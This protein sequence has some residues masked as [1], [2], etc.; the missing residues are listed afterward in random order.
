MSIRDERKMFEQNDVLADS[1]D[2][3]I[4][5]LNSCQILL[6]TNEDSNETL[7]KIV[8]TLNG[9]RGPLL[10]HP[11][12]LSHGLFTKLRVHYRL[13]LKAWRRSDHS[14]NESIQQE[15]LSELCAFLCLLSIGIRDA[16]IQIAEQLFLNKPLIDELIDCLNV[17]MNGQEDPLLLSTIIGMVYAFSRLQIKGIYNPMH[18]PFLDAIVQYLC[19]VELKEK[20]M[21]PN[22]IVDHRPLIKAC[23]HYLVGFK[24]RCQHHLNL[25]V[26]RSQLRPFTE[27]IQGQN[28][29]LDYC[30]TIENVTIIDYMAT[31]I[32]TCLINNIFTE[33][34]LK[35][36]SSLF[37]TF[38]KI[39]LSSKDLEN[40]LLTSVMVK[41]LYTFS[42]NNSSCR[43]SLTESVILFLSELID[44]RDMG[45][46]DDDDDDTMLNVCRLLSTAC[47]FDKIN[48]RKVTLILINSLP[49]M[50][51][52]NKPMEVCQILDILKCKCQIAIFFV[53]NPFDFDL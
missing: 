23:L 19:S 8:N 24:G 5:V 15:T 42:I 13:L 12:I 41:H 38:I 52:S 14:S 46:D 33:E 36:S 29:S 6:T 44:D 49:K 2:Q 51:V 7:L 20:M 48:A 37:E 25:I 27:W 50:M 11:T 10:Y 4:N 35:I 43:N 17:I 47:S 30:W 18:E 1:L 31:I 26:C 32:S 34:E 16:N 53:M 28:R 21:T 3:L 39:L 40:Y 22:I 45:V 9:Y